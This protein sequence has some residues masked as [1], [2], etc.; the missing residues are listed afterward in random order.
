[1]AETDDAANAKTHSSNKT[2]CGSDSTLV[3]LTLCTSTVP[4]LGGGTTRSICTI[5]ALCG[6]GREADRARKAS[7]SRVGVVSHHFVIAL[8]RH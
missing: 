7:N 6:G 4:P 3:P 1:V 5:S 8:E 2:K